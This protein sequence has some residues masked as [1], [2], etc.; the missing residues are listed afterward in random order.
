MIDH[1]RA[2][3]DTSCNSCNTALPS[4]LHMLSPN[5]RKLVS[6]LASMPRQLEIWPPC[7]ASKCLHP[8]APCPLLY[9]A[10]DAADEGSP[11]FSINSLKAPTSTDSTIVEDLT[12][13][14]GTAV[15]RVKLSL[16]SVPGPPHMWCLLPGETP[17]PIMVGEKGLGGC[18]AG[19]C[20]LRWPVLEELRGALCGAVGQ[21]RLAC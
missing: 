20:S 1:E 21:Q 12:F 19:C 2:A 18:L 10:W 17:L 7:P 15:F 4:S 9:Q 6:D 14:L 8:H 13:K 5:S 16:S 3:M 11:I